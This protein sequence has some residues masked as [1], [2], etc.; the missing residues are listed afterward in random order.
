MAGFGINGSGFVQWDAGEPQK[1]GMWFQVELPSQVTLSEV[2]LDSM[3]GFGG[4]RYPRGY[5][6]QVSTD[7]VTWSG[8]VA[9]GK[10][11][12]PSTRIDFKP[13]EAKVLRVTLT[14]PASDSSWSIQRLRLSEAVKPASAESLVPRVGK[15]PLAEVLDAV[16]TTKGDAQRG[17]RLFAELSCVACHTVRPDE[18]PKGPALDKVVKTYKRRD[19]AEQILVPNKII[20]KGYATHTFAINDGTT[21][22][23]FVVSETPEAVTIRTVTAQEH[24]IPK[25]EIGER[26]TSE[27]SLMPEGL[28]A[29]LTLQD[30]ASLLDFLQGTAT[31]R[32][33]PSP[34]P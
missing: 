20:A 4:G 22:E 11:T 5:K 6:V 3:G 14:T 23:G 10:G 17:Q 9:E 1:P 26:K 16:T 29:N 19:L 31:E 28:V 21:L 18:T 8:P 2:A 25:A 24:K 13:V 33:A 32:A 34:K 30:L 15:I 12:G 7:G 27:K